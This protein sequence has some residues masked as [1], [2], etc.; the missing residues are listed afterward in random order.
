MT[1]QYE[2]SAFHVF[3][4]VWVL[5]ILSELT[6]A[7]QRDVTSY[8]RPQHREIVQKWLTSRPELRLATEADCVNKY[9]LKSTRAEDGKSYHP[10][11]AVGDFNGDRKEDF[12]VALIDRRKHKWKF[13]IA[14]FNGPVGIASVPSFI[15]EKAD[16][17]EGGFFYN[18]EAKPS[19]RRL[20]FCIFDTDNC[21]FLEPRGKGYVVVPVDLDSSE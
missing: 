16:L 9:G 18:K 2:R 7:Q 17:S 3:S 15:I 1:W 19:E 11:Y 20:S 10:Y 5:C 21:Q 12:A 6:A 14:V 4:V 8:L 13:V